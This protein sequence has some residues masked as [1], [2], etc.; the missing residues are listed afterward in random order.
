M[1]L[2][3]DILLSLLDFSLSLS[4]YSRY[5]LEQRKEKGMHTQRYVTFVKLDTF[6]F[7]FTA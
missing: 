4:Y 5:V 1:S 7:T 6:T 3:R 2:S